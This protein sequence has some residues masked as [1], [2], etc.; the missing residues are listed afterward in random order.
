MRHLGTIFFGVAV[1]GYSAY[2]VWRGGLGGRMGPPSLTIAEDPL[3]FWIFLILI[4]LT[5]AFACLYGVAKAFG[6]FR[7]FT[8]LV[9]RLLKLPD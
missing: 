3:L 9:D 6:I 5:G 1:L 2:S 4:A 8:G 7:A